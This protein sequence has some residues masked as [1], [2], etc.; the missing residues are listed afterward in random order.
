MATP[1][2]AQ[3][4]G[5]DPEARLVIVSCDDIGL[6]PATTYGALDALTHGVATTG[7]LMV[8]CPS[9]E[10][11]ARAVVDQDV[12]V[13]L[14]VNCEWDD[15][16]WEPL[17]A[18]RSL[19]RDDGSM[20]RSVEGLLQYGDPIDVGRELRAQIE[21]AQEWG[22]DVTHLNSHM[23]ALQDHRKFQD[24]YLEVAM[25]YRLPVRLS[26]SITASSEVR[27]KARDL[28]VLAPDHLVP[29]RRVGSRPDLVAALE[30]LPPGVT[31][32]HAHPARDTPQ[33]RRVL[34][35]A[36]GRIDDHHLYCS[37]PQFRQALSGVEL[38]GY[39]EVRDLMRTVG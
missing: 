8:P 2:L 25:E 31:E 39:R 12:G 38:I 37:D 29:L 23:Y 1:S 4:L 28:G 11:A 13:H 35:D 16:R 20:F 18:G 3:L 5:R 9:A 15:H 19:R 10:Q 36:T 7:S 22:I 6:L 33:T 34:P 30:R 26:G 27:R 24:L 32:F 17:T 21:R 14:T